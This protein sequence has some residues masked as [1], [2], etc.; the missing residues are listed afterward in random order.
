MSHVLLKALKLSNSISGN[1]LLFFSVDLALYLQ[2]KSEEPGRPIWTPSS[3]RQG[4]KYQQTSNM[5][6]LK[7]PIP[8]WEALLLPSEATAALLGCKEGRPGGVCVQ[9]LKPYKD[10]EALLKLEKQVCTT[11]PES[12]EAEIELLAAPADSSPEFLSTRGSLLTGDP[13]RLLNPSHILLL[14]D[15]CSWLPIYN[16]CNIFQFLWTSCTPCGTRP[17]RAAT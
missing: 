11:Y 6:Q 5:Y 10:L 17:W 2:G 12:M 7:S 4:E 8:R 3:S 16:T 1:F 14:G 9:V 13:T 15:E